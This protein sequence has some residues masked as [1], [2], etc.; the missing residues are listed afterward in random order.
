M[1]AETVT[2]S[3][4][5][6][7]ANLRKELEIGMPN[8]KIAYFVSL[9]TNEAHSNHPTGPDIVFA[10]KVHPLLIAKYLIWCHQI[11]VMCIK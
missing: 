6:K 4:G 3:Q 9:P 8:A 2:G 5:S 7:V 11:F 1:E 10:Q